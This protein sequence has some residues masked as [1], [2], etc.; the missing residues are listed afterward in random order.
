MKSPKAYHKNNLKA[1]LIQAAVGIIQAEGVEALTLRGLAKV[2]GVSRTAP[3]RHFKDKEE[4][5]AAIAEEGFRLLNEAMSRVVDSIPNE[6]T[7]I[8]E[9]FP[10]E[11]IIAQSIEYVRFAQNYSSHFK[12]MFSFNRETLAEQEGLLR[13]ASKSLGGLISSVE[14]CQEA[15]LVKPGDSFQIAVSAWS[16]IHGYGNLVSQGLFEFLSGDQETSIEDAVRKLA[17]TFLE[18]VK[19]KP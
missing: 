11:S 4:L 10:L 5:I 9:S 18:G 7:N 12:V 17:M 19:A 16:L 13:E 2:T 3:Y 1:E 14:A 8:P 6:G 15:Q